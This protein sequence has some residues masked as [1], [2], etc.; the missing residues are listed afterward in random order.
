MILIYI[1]TSC[2]WELKAFASLCLCAGSSETKLLI[3]SKYHNLVNL[4]IHSYLHN[5]RIHK[6]SNIMTLPD[7]WYHI[8]LFFRL[9][10]IPGLCKRRMSLIELTIN[11]RSSWKLFCLFILLL[12]IPVNSYGHGGMVSSLNHTFLWASLNKLFKISNSCTYFRL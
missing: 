6:I 4:S 3:Y 11:H 12:Y 1:D 5:I 8:I 7:L 10:K 2:M 9:L